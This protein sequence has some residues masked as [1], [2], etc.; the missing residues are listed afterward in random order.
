[1]GREPDHQRALE[2]RL[3]DQPEIEVLEVAQAPVDELRR[4][5]GGPRGEV[6]A[7]HQRHAVAAGGSVERHAGAGDPPAH[8][9]QIETL[10]GERAQ[11]D[12]ARDHA[13]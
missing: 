7:L 6:R 8:H 10:L 5:P 3:S 2:E 1:V 9:G 12:V 13:R 4:P 11:R